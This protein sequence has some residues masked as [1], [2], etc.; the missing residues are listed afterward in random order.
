MNPP[1][2]DNAAHVVQLALT[3]IFLLSGVAALLNVFST[4]LGRIS[5]QVDKLAGEP[6]K[7]PLQL[8]RLR[9]RSRYLDI[10]VL[11]AACAGGLT[12]AAALTL[13][14]GEIKTGGAG[15]LLFALFGGA[16]ACAI[17][18]LGAFSLEIVLAGRG[19]RE[20]VD[21]DDR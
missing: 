8:A 4:R 6:S 9:L 21:G 20:K 1:A 7:R 10:A 16:L 14:V 18:A 19:V 3:P 2:V 13:F 12:C 5:D 17:A 15:R 11:L